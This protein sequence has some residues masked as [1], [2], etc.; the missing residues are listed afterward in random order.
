VKT[1]KGFTLIE[2]LVVISIIALLMA[3]LMPALRR[4]RDQARD[5]LCRNRQ[6]QIITGAVMW[7]SQDDQGR[8]PQGGIHGPWGG[9]EEFGFED[10]ISMAIEDYYKI[11]TGVSGIT[12]ANYNPPATT[13]NVEKFVVQLH[14]ST[15]KKLFVCPNLQK[16]GPYY[17]DF[18]LPR[19]K[20]VPLY[21]P[22][23]HG[24]GISPQRWTAR[25]GYAYLGGFDTSKWPEP[26][27]YIKKWRS[28]RTLQ[29]PGNLPLICD[30]NRWF[31]EEGGALSLVHGTPAK[32]EIQGMV[33]YPQRDYPDARVNIG[34][35]DGSV[36]SKK[37]KDCAPRSQLKY[38]GSMERRRYYLFF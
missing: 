28:P 4:A 24:W 13:S 30:R 18:P 34:Y 19:D 10:C 7:A 16:E 2:L 12:G 37:L 20:G 33:Y 22:Y 9:I 38:G 32:L 1:K 31:L 29:D 26:P 8:L 3:I 27:S 23:I 14:E 5:V 25:L 17:P 15:L 21:L 35:L 36:T 11:A 6:K